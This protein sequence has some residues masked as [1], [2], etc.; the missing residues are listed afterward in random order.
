MQII[1][2]KNNGIIE[3]VW[4]DYGPEPVFAITLESAQNYVEADEE[5]EPDNIIYV[6]GTERSF[7]EIRIVQDI[8]FSKKVF[9][10]VRQQLA[11]KDKEVYIKSLQSELA[12]A[13]KLIKDLT[14]K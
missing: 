2:E 11:I 13:K 5:E 10:K 8:T 14:C 9:R 3:E 7:R 4:I 1:I 6:N 12:E